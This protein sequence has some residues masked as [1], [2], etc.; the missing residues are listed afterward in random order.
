MKPQRRRD[1][2]VRAR[3]DRRER[4]S[5]HRRAA[6]DDGSQEASRPPAL[7]LLGEPDCGPEGE[8][9][10][11]GQEIAREL[12][13][14]RARQEDVGHEERGEDP[15][16]GRERPEEG[17]APAGGPERGEAEERPEAPEHELPGLVQEVRD[18]DVLVRVRHEARVADHRALLGH[19]PPEFVKGE[20]RV[21]LAEKE[22]DEGREAGN[23]E[24]KRPLAPG[25]R[26]PAGEKDGDGERKE[27]R[28]GARLRRERKAGQRAGEKGVAQASPAAR[29]GPRR[30]ARGGRKA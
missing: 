27:E 10:V 15:L 1:G 17:E 26:R 6:H 16:D 30:R 5:P 3:V 11:D 18:A 20:E 24:E 7:G 9:R 22:R 23:R 14:E 28:R 12:H 29:D 13:L 19:R 8:E 2:A 4:E 21:R 25:A